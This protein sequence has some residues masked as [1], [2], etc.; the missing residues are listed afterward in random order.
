MRIGSL[1]HR[2]KFQIQVP[3]LDVM[4]GTGVTWKDG[5]VVWG[6]IWPITA[7][8][9]LKSGQLTGEITHRIKIRYRDDV[10]SSMRIKYKDIYYAIINVPMNQNMDD[11]TLEFLCKETEAEAT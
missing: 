7:S 10:D 8:E 11:R 5:P 6:S 9:Q 4:G 1:R 2:L 3:T